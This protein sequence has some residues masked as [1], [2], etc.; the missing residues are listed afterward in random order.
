MIHRVDGREAWGRASGEGQDF[1]R[2]VGTNPTAPLKSRDFTLDSKGPGVEG[3]ERR[4]EEADPL[5]GKPVPGWRVLPRRGEGKAG[6]PCA[7]RE[8]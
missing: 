8:F 2:R 7:Y 4:S 6:T 3:L 1:E 5:I